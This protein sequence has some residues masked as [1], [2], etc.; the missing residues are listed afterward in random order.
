MSTSDDLNYYYYAAS[1]DVISERIKLIQS[2]R[3]IAALII[4]IIS[5][6]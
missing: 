4:N 3:V 1:I 2:R 5:R 6:R